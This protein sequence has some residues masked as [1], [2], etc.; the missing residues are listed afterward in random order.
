VKNEFPDTVTISKEFREP[1]CFDT[2]RNLSK[3]NAGHNGLIGNLPS[4]ANLSEWDV[5]GVFY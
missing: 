2:R 4:N 3:G 1:T 5:Q